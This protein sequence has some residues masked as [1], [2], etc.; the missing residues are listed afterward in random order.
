MISGLE[1][2]HFRGIREG[3]IEG[4]AQVNVLIG[5]NGSG[6]ST[7]LEGLELLAQQWS[8]P[9]LLSEH[10]SQRLPE[11]RNERHLAEGLWYGRE[12]GSLRIAAQFN[13]QKFSVTM[14]RGPNGGV[15]INAEPNPHQGQGVSP[16]LK[17]YFSRLLFLDGTRALSKKVEE[18]LWD[19][20]FLSGAS[21]T[22]TKLFEKI[23]GL[24]VHNVTFT[25]GG[26]L[27]VDLD[28][29]PL[30][31]DDLGSGMRIS[32][33]ILL[34]ALCARASALLLEEFDAYQ[35]KTSM[36]ELARA[37]CD[38]AAEKNVQLFLTTHSLESVHAF[39]EAAKD[40]GKEWLK[41]FPLSLET[42]GVLRTRGMPGE[43]ARKLLD[44]G[45][46]LREITSYAPQA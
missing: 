14:N 16:T 4:L 12:I 40:K 31:L 2:H 18:T 27:L 21:R 28:P 8:D 46:D 36:A 32:F 45:L 11:R 38:V 35:Y 34:A 41:V 25:K 17:D 23:Y 33:R 6:K 10:R 43:D 26:D 37:L 29:L 5:P 19:K 3:K 22:L 7:I 42:D 15:G 20:A 13:G 39:L 1:F 44:S 24:T 9:D 30:R